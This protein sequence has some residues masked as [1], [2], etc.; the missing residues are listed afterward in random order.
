MLALVILE[1][2]IWTKENIFNFLAHSSPEV[3][4]EHTTGIS[5]RNCDFVIEKEWST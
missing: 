2:I 3:A 5:E 1:I 4:T